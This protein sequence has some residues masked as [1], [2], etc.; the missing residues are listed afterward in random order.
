MTKSLATAISCMVA[1]AAL[2]AVSNTQGQ[3]TVTHAGKKPKDT[4]RPI[5]VAVLTF[6]ASD[7][8]NPKLGDELR[9]MVTAVLSGDDRFELVDRTSLAQTL[10][11]H[12]LN[13]TGLASAE[14]AIRVGKLVGARILVTGRAFHLGT[15]N[16]LAAKLV[17]TETS[18]VEAVMVRGDAQQDL[19][20][21]A[22]RL[23]DK[24]TDCVVANARQLTG[25]D[26]SRVDPL[27]AMIARASKRRDKPVLAVV[28]KEEHIV[29]PRPAILGSPVDPAVETELKRILVH[30][31]YTI[32]D[33]DQNELADWSGKETWPKSLDGVDLVITGE[34][35]SEFGS[36]IGN[37][38]NCT[39]RAE[40]NAIRRKDGRIV[41]A[42]RAT[43]RAVD[44]AE[45]TA[46]KKALQKAGSQMA[47]AVLRYLLADE[48]K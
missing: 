15:H 41:L 42:E 14:Q 12:E 30:A 47:A 31:G 4:L 9:E 16:Y 23:C 3:D 6:D 43:T 25:D 19:G 21:L 8:G 46:G 36:R 40:I 5:T 22:M 35:L 32:K 48:S 44:L 28:V 7:P 2:V 18:R 17:G 38:V 20:E 26:A 39:A 33:V 1:V 13:L 24:I 37:L 34:A 45:N 27:P 29:G 10:A 11:E